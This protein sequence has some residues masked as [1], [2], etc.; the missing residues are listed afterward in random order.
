MNGVK[1]ALQGHKIALVQ[2]EPHVLTFSVHYDL[3]QMLYFVSCIIT[4]N[5]V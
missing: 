4:T 2:E 1:L 5:S 3:R